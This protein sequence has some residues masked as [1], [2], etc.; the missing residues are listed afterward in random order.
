MIAHTRAELLKLRSTQT[1]LLVLAGMSGLVGLVIAMHVLAPAAAEVT[2]RSSQLTVFEAGTRVAML[3][4]ALT[5]ALTIT[6]EIRYRTIRPTFLVTPRRGP[7]VAA[8]LAVGALTGAL[9]GLLAEALMTGAALAAFSARDID[10]QLGSGDYLQLLTGGSA[11]A[12]LWAMIGVGVGAIVR[13]QVGALV[14]LFAWM[15]LLETLLLGFLPSI[16]RLAPGSAGLALA[17][18]TADNLLAP[19]PALLALTLYTIAIPAAGWLAVR[20]GEID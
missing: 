11:A 15:L 6:A 9:S 14:G 7:V 19:A 10:N 4:A 8:K 3:F 17:G 13:N 12:A 20:R 1:A 16:G 5:G 18:E 2:T